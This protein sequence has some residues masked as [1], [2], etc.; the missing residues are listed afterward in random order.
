MTQDP[1]P[2]H[3]AQGKRKRRDRQQ[4]AEQAKRARRH[5]RRDSKQKLKHQSMREQ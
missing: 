4:I 3:S 1:D 5:E 2:K